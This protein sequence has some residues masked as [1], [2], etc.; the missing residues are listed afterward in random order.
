MSKSFSGQFGTPSRASNGADAMGEALGIDRSQSLTTLPI[1]KIAPN[2]DQP[3]R[4]FSQ[5]KLDELEVRQKS[6]PEAIGSD[7]KL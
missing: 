1:D 5:G 2:P 4:H 3:R 6:R 7:T